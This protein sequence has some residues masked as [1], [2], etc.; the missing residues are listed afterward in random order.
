[1]KLLL[2]FL[3]SMAKALLV[4]CDISLSVLDK[5]LTWTFVLQIMGFVIMCQ[6]SM[7]LC[8]MMRNHINLSF[9]IIASMEQLLTMF[10]IHVTFQKN[11]NSM[12]TRAAL[13]FLQLLNM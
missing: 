2:C 9:S 4:L 13:N 3:L 10:Y 8:F 1:M 5:E 12:F 6:G 11:P 7:L